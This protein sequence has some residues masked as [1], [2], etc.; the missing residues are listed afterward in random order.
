[1]ISVCVH[2]GFVH[3]DEASLEM[4]IKLA[5]Q[6]VKWR[7]SRR[8]SATGSGQEFAQSNGVFPVILPQLCGIRSVFMGYNEL[9]ACEYTNF[10]QLKLARPVQI[11]FITVWYSYNFK[12]YQIHKQKTHIHSKI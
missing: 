11:F 1:M 12:N 10:T 6:S 3:D 8:S 4:M 9:N 2:H 7:Q 5:I